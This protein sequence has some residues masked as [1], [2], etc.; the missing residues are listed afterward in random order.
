MVGLAAVAVLVLVA[1]AG[2]TSASATRLCSVNTAPCPAGSAYPVGTVLS[3]STNTFTIATSGGIANPR[4]TCTS[5]TEQ[6]TTTSVGGGAGVAVDARVD[7]FDLR[8]CTSSS[9]AG[10]TANPTVSGL[11]SPVRINWASGFDGNLSVATAPVW[12]FTCG[13]VSPT[14]TC[15]YGGNAITYGFTGG[16]PARFTF[17][18]VPIAVLGVTG[19]PT[20]AR[21]TATFNATPSTTPYYLTNS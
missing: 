13:A 4:I 17:S 2:T 16:R 9:P 8:N 6:L 15:N 3:S 5:V 1:F 14:F 20:A 10:C 21:V 18:T 7:N 11:G 19:C 12:T